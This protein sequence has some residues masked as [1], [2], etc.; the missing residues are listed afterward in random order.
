MN[1]STHKQQGERRILSFKGF[2]VRNG[3]SWCI[4]FRI[5]VNVS[6]NKLIDQNQILG[7]CTLVL[8]SFSRIAKCDTCK[9]NRHILC[10]VLEENA[11]V[12]V[13]FTQQTHKI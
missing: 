13:L 2:G 10:P 12:L 9:S 11:A 7:S 4:N 5:D 1:Q 6:D 3:N 8:S